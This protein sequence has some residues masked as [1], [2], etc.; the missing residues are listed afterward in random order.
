MRRPCP[1]RGCRF[2]GKKGYPHE[3]KRTEETKKEESRR[4]RKR[5]RGKRR[6]GKTEKRKIVSILS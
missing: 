4:K 2:M 6:E 3:K 1:D 5:R